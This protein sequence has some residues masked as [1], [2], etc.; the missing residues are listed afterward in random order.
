[1]VERYLSSWDLTSPTDPSH[2]PPLSPLCLKVNQNQ[3][4][5]RRCWPNRK[6]RSDAPCLLETLGKQIA[7]FPA[8]PH[9][10]MSLIHMLFCVHRFAAT[11][12][13]LRSLI[14]SHWSTSLSTSKKHAQKT[15]RSKFLPE[16]SELEAAAAAA[17]GSD[18]EEPTSKSE[19]KADAKDDEKVAEDI[20]GAGLRKVRMGQFQDTGR[21]K[22]FA[23]SLYFI[24]IHP[25]EKTPHLVVL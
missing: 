18:S 1:M 9:L 17:E 15:P 11:E 12:D 10:I 7:L 23:L 24:S 25:L 2:P 16:K 20:S 19:N 14:E 4:R 8:L 6:T 13:A 3:R 21:C 22:G 5:P